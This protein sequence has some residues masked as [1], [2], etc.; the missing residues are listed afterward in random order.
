M[1]T[2]RTRRRRGGSRRGAQSASNFAWGALLVVL[3]ALGATGGYFAWSYAS[4]RPSINAATLCPEDGPTGAFVVLLDL[5][6]PL[7]PQQGARL[8]ALLEDRIAGL[9][10]DTMISFGVVSN[11][12]TRRGTLFSSCKP[13]DG[14]EAS[15]IYENPTLITQRFEED[16]MRPLRAG[17]DEAMRAGVEDRSPIMESL[18]TLIAESPAFETSDGAHELVIVSDLLQHSETLSFYRGEGWEELRASGGTERLARNLGGAW[19][20]VLRVP[21]PGASALARE[22][23]D[24]FWARYFD[25]Q[26][27][28]APISV[29]VLGD[30]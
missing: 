14:R 25:M 9:P 28:R 1:A 10:Q 21:R 6:D 5:T 24:A 29:E 7:T 13:A 27:A 18:Q 8:R 26:G 16:F 30:L 17:L 19:V 23:V 12:E 22:Q 20:S 2:R 15:R 4:S 3:V 11:D